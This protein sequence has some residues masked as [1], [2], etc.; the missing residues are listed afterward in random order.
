MGFLK[1]W[2]TTA[3]GVG[4][5]LIVLGRLLHGDGVSMDEVLAALAGVGL[6]FSADAGK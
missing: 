4:L 3:A 2:K 6:V 5:L 1:N